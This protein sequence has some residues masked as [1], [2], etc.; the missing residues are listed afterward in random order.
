MDALI[1]HFQAPLMSF[2]GPQIDQIGPTGLY[3]TMSQVAGLIANGLGLTHAETDRTQVLQD[4]MSLA[5]ALIRE[6]AEL[7]DYQS[8]DL[9]QD[10]LRN[11]AWTSHG[12]AEHRAG[13]PVAKF[14]THIR[15][16]FYRA[17]ASVL[18]A[19]S[20]S[21][22]HENP[23]LAAIEEALL[24]P[25]RPLFIGRKPCLP[26]TPLV[27][28]YVESAESLIDAIRQVPWRFPDRWREIDRSGRT[29]SRVWAEWPVP[30]NYTAPPNSGIS[31]HRVVDRRDWRNQLHGGE[32]AV[33]RGPIEVCSPRNS[34]SGGA[35]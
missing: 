27:I 8:V 21:P 17:D 9:G 18:S 33:A 11:P 10:H 19:I 1:L 7:R 4:R 35:G 23:T 14:G 28:G 15:I 3:P 22:R 12:A 31:T 13:G 24:Q 20:F 29:D 6:G 26:A 25:A 5:S 2:G 30:D 16:R 32:R 34:D